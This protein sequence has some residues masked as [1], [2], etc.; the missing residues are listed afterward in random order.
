[1]DG[2]GNAWGGAVSPDPPGVREQAG[3]PGGMR[4]MIP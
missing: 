1:M 4:R 2:A 3:A